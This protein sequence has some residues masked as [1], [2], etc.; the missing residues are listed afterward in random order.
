VVAARPSARRVPAPRALAVSPRAE[1]DNGPD[2][3]NILV[4]GGGGV[5]MECTKLLKDMGS[6]VWMLQRTDVSACL[7]EHLFSQRERY[8]SF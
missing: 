3:A 1:L 4:C 7:F 5:A 2:N 8:R 6:W